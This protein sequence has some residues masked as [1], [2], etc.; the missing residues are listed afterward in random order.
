MSCIVWPIVSTIVGL[1]DPRE[2]VGRAAA[3]RLSMSLWDAQLYA[4]VECIR[5][6]RQLSATQPA[7]ATA[8]ASSTGKPSALLGWLLAMARAPSASCGNLGPGEWE[9]GAQVQ[10][11]SCIAGRP[12][13]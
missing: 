1:Q 9:G 5:Y 8:F 6:L 2:V 13:A 12:S 7:A 10:T 3:N 4:V 11:S